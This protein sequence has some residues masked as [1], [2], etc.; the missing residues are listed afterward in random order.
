MSTKLVRFIRSHDDDD[1]CV[2]LRHGPYAGIE[3]Y[4]SQFVDEM[5]DGNFPDLDKLQL[6]YGE[7]RIEGTDD[8]DKY[9]LYVRFPS[10][11]DETPQQLASRI[12]DAYDDGAVAGWF[13]IIE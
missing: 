12:Q 4:F 6:V 8:C 5:S 11:P 1:D 2:A 3:A 7:M 9:S 10:A 13:Q